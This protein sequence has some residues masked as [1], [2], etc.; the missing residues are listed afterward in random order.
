MISILMFDHIV[1]PL[2]QSPSSLKSKFLDVDI[3]LYLVQSFITRLAL[4]RTSTCRCFA[5]TNLWCWDMLLYL[6]MA[7]V[8]LVV[9]R[10]EASAWSTISR[11]IGTMNERL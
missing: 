5:R 4:L 10:V 2:R 6:T 8:N 9:A 3:F 11:Q 1:K 7:P